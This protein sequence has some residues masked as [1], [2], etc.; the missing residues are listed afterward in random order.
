M[1][2]GGA[3]GEKKWEGEMEIARVPEKARS[4]EATSALRRQIRTR[5]RLSFGD[6]SWQD[7]ACTP[8]QQDAG[9][10]AFPRCQCLATWMGKAEKLWEPKQPGRMLPSRA[11][12]TAKV[13][14]ETRFS[15]VAMMNWVTASSWGVKRP[16]GSLE[17]SSFVRWGLFTQE[18]WLIQKDSLQAMVDYPHWDEP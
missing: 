1:G 11:N 10:D 18:Q 4:I 9:Q 7:W 15:L 14:T 8:A 17:W 6:L 2:R 16:R 12:L 3:G 13:F 5:A